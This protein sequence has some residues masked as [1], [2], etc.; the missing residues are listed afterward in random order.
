MMMDKPF[1]VPFEALSVSQQRYAING[2]V[3]D[4]NKHERRFGLLAEHDVLADEC[5]AIATKLRRLSAEFSAIRYDKFDVVF[6]KMLDEGL[7]QSSNAD[8]EE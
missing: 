3:D 7:K 5:R 4:L 1:Y 8:T 6:G 2:L